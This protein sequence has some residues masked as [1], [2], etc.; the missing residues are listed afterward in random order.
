M[1]NYGLGSSGVQ[2]VLALLVGYLSAVL[3]PPLLD[4]DMTPFAPLRL[5]RAVNLA[6]RW[7]T[8]RNATLLQKGSNSPTIGTA[9]TTPATSHINNFSTSTPAKMD[10]KFNEAVVHR[11]TIY[12]LQHKSPIPDKKI[13]EIV[14]AAVKHVPSSF[15]SQSTRV[16]VLLK[17]EHTKF[18]NIVEEILKGI[19]P[20]NSWDH[21]AQRINGFKNGYGSVSASRS[22]PHAETLLTCTADPLLRRPRCRQKAPGHLPALRRQVPAVV[23]A[24]KRHAPVHALDCAGNGRPGLQPAALQPAAGPEGVGD[25]EGACAVESEGAARVRHAGR[26]RK[27]EFAAEGPAAAQ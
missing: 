13:Q 4:F 14:E 17:D 2:I 25:L 5:Q 8:S 1:R 23:R 15:N 21:T 18:W 27:G 20:E 12:Q 7:T 11:R 24:H 9:F 6:Q 26:G 3:L 10:M 16:L 19:V 22:E